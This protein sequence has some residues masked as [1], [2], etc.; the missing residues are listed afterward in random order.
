LSSSAQ[1]SRNTLTSNSAD[2]LTDINRMSNTLGTITTK[3]QVLKTQIQ[4][5]EQQIP[6]PAGN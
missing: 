4:N 5:L 1:S 6:V 2:I 3:V